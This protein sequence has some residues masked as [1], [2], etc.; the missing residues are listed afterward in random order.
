MSTVSSQLYIYLDP[1]P[2]PARNDSQHR[3]F[4]PGQSFPVVY[5]RLSFGSLAY[6][7]LLQGWKIYIHWGTDFN[8]AI[9]SLN[10]APFELHSEGIKSPYIYKT[11]ILSNFLL[12]EL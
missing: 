5:I 6:I 9:D 12:V 2:P 4:L 10:K 3:E 1:P 8:T 11:P 7:A